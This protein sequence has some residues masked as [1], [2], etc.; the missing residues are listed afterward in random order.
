MLCALCTVQHWHTKVLYDFLSLV[1]KFFHTIKILF[2]FISIS[3][4]FHS[5]SL[6]LASRSLVRS[7][8]QK[9]S[10]TIATIIICKPGTATR[11]FFFI[12]LLFFRCCL[13]T[14][15]FHLKD[16]FQLKWSLLFV[17]YVCINSFYRTVKICFFLL[18]FIRIG[19][20]NNEN[21]DRMS[22]SEREKNVQHELHIF[23][24]WVIVIV[25]WEKLCSQTD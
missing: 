25:F 13:Q 4:L 6:Y 17:S 8:A 23:W 2:I 5:L 9:M 11:G 15:D 14:S 3:N 19:V 22:E 21:W 1:K 12:P 24:I 10:T 16:N 7:S 18:L 20:K